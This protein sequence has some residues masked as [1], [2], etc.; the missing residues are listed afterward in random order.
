V[1]TMYWNAEKNTWVQV[2]DDTVGGKEGIASLFGTTVRISA[3]AN[4]FI[5]TGNGYARAYDILT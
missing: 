5:A 1:R 4:R 2:A 3:D